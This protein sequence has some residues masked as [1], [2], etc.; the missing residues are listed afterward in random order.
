MIVA[1]TS[2]EIQFL[3]NHKS[4]SMKLKSQVCTLEQAKRLK[5]L[6]VDQTGYY[7]YSHPVDNVHRSDDGKSTE[8]VAE[9]SEDT[10]LC[11]TSLAEFDG[12]PNYSAFTVAE[13]GVM[14]DYCSIERSSVNG[15]EGQF[16]FPRG[17]KREYYYFP[18]EAEARAQQLIIYLEKGWTTAAEV[19]QRLQ[20]P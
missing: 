20:N 10:E 15:H 19:N 12:L 9:Y 7:S 17:G 3:L 6:G 16:C 13:L 8:W 5:V 1:I 14:L 2:K 18:T 4:N 11:E